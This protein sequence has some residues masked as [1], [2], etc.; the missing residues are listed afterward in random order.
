MRR[1]GTIS[2]SNLQIILQKIK[3]FFQLDI[4]L[5]YHDGAGNNLS[6]VY[7]VANDNGLK[8]TTCLE[9]GARLDIHNSNLQLLDQPDFSNIPKT[10]LDY[11]N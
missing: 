9:Y 2:P 8:H 10:P 4:N 6:A 1:S 3:R 5:F 11:R 7:K